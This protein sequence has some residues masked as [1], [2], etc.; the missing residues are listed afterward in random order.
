[1]SVSLRDSRAFRADQLFIERVYGDFVNDLAPDS[2]GVFP[3]LAGLAIVEGDDDLQRWLADPQVHLLTILLHKQPAGFA[4]V[5]IRRGSGPP[6]EAANPFRMTEFFIARP[7][8]R[9]G[10][11]RAA[12]RLLFDR[13]AGEWLVTQSRRNAPAVAFWRR[14][15][16]Q[17]SGGRY[18]ERAGGDEIQ[19]R[20]RTGTAPSGPVPE[21]VIPGS[22]V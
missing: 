19:Q 4:V 6:G 2:T 22:A 7:L 9:R 15:I 14:V 18:Q 17:Y 12:V 21:T 5:S 20:L 1:M 13:F 3:P 10:V 16:A 11:G 8:R